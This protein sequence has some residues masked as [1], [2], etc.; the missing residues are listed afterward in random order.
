MNM[1][2]TIDWAIKMLQNFSKF[3]PIVQYHFSLVPKYPSLIEKLNKVLS[4]YKGIMKICKQDDLSKDSA[5][6]YNVIL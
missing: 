4:S 6:K 2:S 1:F 3:N 5:E